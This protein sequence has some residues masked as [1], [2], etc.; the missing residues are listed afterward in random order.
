MNEIT[1]PDLVINP[2]AD[3]SSVFGRFKLGPLQKGSGITLGNSLRRVLLSSIP[4]TCITD[5]RI[6]HVLHEFAALPGVVEDITEVILNLKRLVLRSVAH[7]PIKISLR[8]TGPKQVTAADIM[9]HQSVTVVEPSTYI[10]EITDPAAEFNME[11]TL[12]RG[13]GFQSANTVDKSGSDLNT[14]FLDRAFSPVRRVTFKVERDDDGSSDLLVVDVTTNG[15][16]Q[17]E[18]ALKLAARIMKDHFAM[19]TDFSVESRLPDEEFRSVR[20]DQKAEDRA[21]DVSIKELEFSVRSRN[22]LEQEGIK[23]LGEL[24]GKRASELLA[25]KNFGKKSLTEIRDKLKE[26][27]LTLKDEEVTK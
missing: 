21:S 9:P 14:I 4:G 3:N 6:D 22:C 27:G 12:S 13:I 17:P 23:T 24:A 18:E 25:I 26:F 10:C 5:I 11:M 7:E 8:T 1:T 20:D 2:D 19:L 16:I 15:G